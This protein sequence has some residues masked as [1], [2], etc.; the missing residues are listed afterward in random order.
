MAARVPSDPAAFVADIPINAVIKNV[1]DPE[2]GLTVQYRY[3]YDVKMGRLDMILTWIFGV[4]LGV[5]GHGVLAT[6][7]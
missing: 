1:S 2:T 3:H 5:S 6:L 4:A 7:T